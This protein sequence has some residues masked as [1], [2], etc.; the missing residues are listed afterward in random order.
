MH[1]VLPMT[2]HHAVLPMVLL[3][4]WWL[5]GQVPPGGRSLVAVV[6]IVPPAR[7]YTAHGLV[8]Q[9]SVPHVVMLHSHLLSS[10]ARVYRMDV[11]HV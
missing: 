5:A 3:K 7:Q 2:L 10:S 6:L 11:L 4:S 8:L 1:D 9:H